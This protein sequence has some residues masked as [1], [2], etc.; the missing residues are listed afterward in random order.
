[1]AEPQAK[2]S[3][4]DLESGVFV[5]LGSQWGDE[6]K[7]KLVD[8]LASQADVVCRAQVRM[9]LEKDL[10]LPIDSRR[11]EITPV[12]RSSWAKRRTTFIFFRGAISSVSLVYLRYE[13]YLC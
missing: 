2:K 8:Q 12:I 6:G 5:V 4:D 7:G 3:K 11:E 13:R 10:L 9:F 1:M